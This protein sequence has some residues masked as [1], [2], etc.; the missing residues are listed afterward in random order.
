MT[1]SEGL[2]FYMPPCG[3]SLITSEC[4]CSPPWILCLL[5]TI[6]FR[7]NGIWND[8]LLQWE[9]PGWY[10]ILQQEVHGY[11][12]SLS[13]ARILAMLPSVAAN[14]ESFTVSIVC[15]CRKFWISCDSTGLKTTVYDIP[16]FQRKNHHQEQINLR[17]EDDRY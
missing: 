15:C 6:C 1:K 8:R 17:Y 11:C 7:N 5:L 12:T 16:S 13:K 9:V 4:C 14:F 10:S 2:Y 3:F